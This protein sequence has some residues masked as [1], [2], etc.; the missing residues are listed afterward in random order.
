[1]KIKRIL[2]PLIGTGSLMTLAAAISCSNA[3]STKKTFDSKKALASKGNLEQQ[4]A[5][6][7]EKLNTQNQLLNQ[8]TSLINEYKDQLADLK[9]ESN[10]LINDNLL[11][12]NEI[13]YI[14]TFGS[15]DL[16][17]IIDQYLNLKDVDLEDSDSFTKYFYHFVSS[18]SADID[19]LTKDTSLKNQ[20]QALWDQINKLDWANTQVSQLIASVKDLVE[21]SKLKID[22]SELF[23]EKEN[24]NAASA[25]IVTEVK[26]YIDQ[27]FASE[28][29]SLDNKVSSLTTKLTTALTFGN[30]EQRDSK[31]EEY[32][33]EFQ[34]NEESRIEK[35]AQYRDI[36]AKLVKL[37]NQN[38][39][40]IDAAKA[41]IDKLTAQKIKLE[42]EYQVV[43]G[44]LYINQI[45]NLDEDGITDAEAGTGNY[46]T[47]DEVK[48]LLV[49]NYKFEQLTPSFA[50]T[51]KSRYFIND[52]NSTYSAPVFLYDTS[53]VSGS[54]ND[55]FKDT[56][57]ADLFQREHKG[58]SIIKNFITSID[59][60]KGTY[61]E[62]HYVTKPSFWRYKLELADAIIVTVKENDQLKEYTFDQDDAWLVERPK[63]KEITYYIDGKTKKTEEIKVYSNTSVQRRSSNPRSIN[64]DEF[65]KKL[66]DAINVKFRIRK[67]GFWTNSNGEATKYHIKAK[68]FA[69]G[70]LRTKMYDTDYRDSHGGSKNL[71]DLIRKI[72]ISPGNN[73]TPKSKY[74]NEYLF[75]LFNVSSDKLASVKDAVEYADGNEYFVAHKKNEKEE[76]DWKAFLENIITSYT[77]QPA[78][79]EYIEEQNI[80]NNVPLWAQT[81]LSPAELN[82]IKDQISSNA[83]GLAR[84]SGVYWYGFDIKSTLF[85][86]KYYGVDYNTD[87]LSIETRLNTNYWDTKFTSDPQT[88]LKFIN[89]YQNRSQD[90]AAYAAQSFNLYIAGLSSS[91]AFGNLSEQNI[92]K[93]KLNPE[94]YGLTQR[95]SLNKSSLTSKIVWSLTP[96]KNKDANT[97]YNDAFAKLFWGTDAQSLRDGTAKNTVI[98]ASSGIANEF[99]S[100][101]T[102]SLNWQQLAAQINSPREVLPWISGFAPDSR[103]NGDDK[104]TSLPKDKWTPRGNWDFL[105][106]TFV[107]DAKTGE[108]ID[109]GKNSDGKDIGTLL[110]PQDTN[111]NGLPA[112]EEVRTVAF[113]VLK[114][115]MK[116]LLDDFYAQNPELQ[117]Q[118]I[119]ATLYYR[120][121]NYSDKQVNA[122][123]LA[124]RSWNA[125]DDRLD[126]KLKKPDNTKDFLSYYLNSSIPIALVGWG[127]D[128]DGIGS[129]FDGYSW[130]ANLMN[131]LVSIWNDEKY[132]DYM[133]KAYPEIKRASDLLKTFTSN[134]DVNYRFSID[135]SKWGELTSAEINDLSD[136]LGAKKFENGKLVNLDQATMNLPD[137]E[138]YQTG[139]TISSRFWLFYTD[140]SNKKQIIDLAQ[141]FT[142][143]LGNSLNPTISISQSPFVNVIVNPNYII[144]SNLSDYADLTQYRVVNGK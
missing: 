87:T 45:E 30:Q 113:K 91:V 134:P 116:Q 81:Q 92:A 80:N 61:K 65:D 104:D 94:K 106:S 138:K 42:K 60:T 39:K 127:Y 18:Q 6:V 44:D 25:K 23:P 108:R 124:V 52:Y 141:E 34:Q 95:Q 41:E 57:T 71:D 9:N 96:S 75:N 3:N 63:T 50:A 121:T 84:Q 97:F 36:K 13:E 114:A 15:K 123:N 11:L 68:D 77:V 83:L 140:Q 112:E 22:L 8:L 142:N 48:N 119:S 32:S 76:T 102:S 137:N 62:E 132:R 69:I 10:K 120:Y 38:N 37:E 53:I 14:K 103:I 126:F 2:L 85:A 59:S 136:L 73:F 86:G 43:L 49:N 46:L 110:K 66:K 1:M 125:L 31:I 101:L 89:K 128:Y 122:Y 107:V 82:N 144:P 28:I 67:N 26:T 12:N 139:G 5:D 58:R 56:A 35:S 47:K 16:T 143:M 105:N 78:P 130:S 100:I 129:G 17:Y 24:T 98:H 118:K 64:S 131:I 99:R 21:K 135:P 115:K 117:G 133:A 90:A 70:Y 4:I 33:K 74:G 20:T 40:Q 51:A 93:V 19:S 72:F 54:K 27:Q 55:P 111:V 88:I 79:S 109:F 29:E 7:N